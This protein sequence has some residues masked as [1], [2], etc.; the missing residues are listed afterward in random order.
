MLG[1]LDCRGRL[2]TK[3]PNKIFPNLCL[4]LIPVRLSAIPPLV[5]MKM[6][7]FSTWVLMAFFTLLSSSAGEELFE[8]SVWPEWPVVEAGKALW[9]NCSTNCTYPTKG[10]IETRNINTTMQQ[11][12]AH[13]KVFHLSNISQN[14]KI[15]CYFIC[16]NIQKQKSV[17]VIVYRPPLQVTLS[18]QPAWVIVGENF[19][20]TCHVP[21]VVPLENLTVTL[22]QGTEK[23]HRQTFVTVS[24]ALQDAWLTFNVT[25]R[26]EDSRSNFSCHAELDL[27]PHSEQLF[28][29]S[30]EPKMLEIFGASGKAVEETGSGTFLE[31]SDARHYH[32]YNSAA[33][34]FCD[35][36]LPVFCL[37][38]TLA[39]TPNRRIRG[40]C[41]LEKL[42]N[43]MIIIQND[44]KDQ[45]VGDAFVI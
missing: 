35:L 4:F 42:Q 29:A 19:T 28:S 30:S 26:R 34:G 10:G 17:N 41:C 31:L 39:S 15:F 44:D 27:R 3:H 25:A 14:T 6:L 5:C 43:Q 45:R 8:V 20:L 12:E 40:T 1:I 16:S 7:L 32:H 2:L 33:A 36:S 9:I 24:K 21:N 13:W 11:E 23:L 18:L 22:L 38:A 37:W